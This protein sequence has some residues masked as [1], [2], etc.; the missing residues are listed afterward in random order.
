LLV[1]EH[2][3]YCADEDWFF[4]FKVVNTYPSASKVYIL[5]ELTQKIGLRL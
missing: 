1:I 5:K 4:T 2:D 3:A